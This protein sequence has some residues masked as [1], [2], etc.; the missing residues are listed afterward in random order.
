MSNRRAHLERHLSHEELRDAIKKADDRR[1]VRRLC[2]VRNLYA[3]DTIEEAAWRAERPEESVVSD[4]NG[5][6]KTPRM[7]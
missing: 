3:G 6:T 4:L 5:G 1:V 2:F 7:D